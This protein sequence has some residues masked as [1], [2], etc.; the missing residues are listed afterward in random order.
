LDRRLLA[1]LAL[2]LGLL[3]GCSDD[4]RGNA[5]EFGVAG[6]ERAG[7]RQ[8]DFRFT[9]PSLTGEA[10]VRVL[11]PVGYRESRRRYPVLY[12][13]HGAGGDEKTW[14]WVGRAAKSTKRHQV[15]VVMP[16]G[17]AEGFY[18]DWF[19]GGEGGPPQWE[20]FHIGELIP[21][22]D[23]RFR[24]RKGRR[25]RAVAGVSMGGFGALAY[26]ARHP[27]LFANATSISG[28]MDTSYEPVRQAVENVTV[29]GE[30][31]VWGPFETERERW[32][33][34]NPLELAD[35]LRGVDVLL[36]TGNG[37]AGGRYASPPDPGEA[38]IAETNLRLNARLNELGVRHLLR[39]YRGAH[40]MQYA[41]WAL[42]KALPRIVKDLAGGRPPKSR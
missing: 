13:L 8:L 29:D 41:G 26:A 25:Y 9:T 16:D 39:T 6:P 14:T 24:T 42:S 38:Q 30:P 12:L 27:R 37:Q 4:G 28:P 11:L 33:A 17:G 40:T 34:H 32:R 2:A 23:G 31:A 19:N 35:R 7:S 21:W 18:S 22:V 20:S 1:T 5:P 36:Y 3:G 10:G 15:I